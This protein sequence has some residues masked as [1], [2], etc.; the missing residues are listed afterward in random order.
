[1][2]STFLQ[3][4]PQ[5]TT[6]LCMHACYSMGE[7]LTRKNFVLVVRNSERRVD[8]ALTSLIQLWSGKTGTNSELGRDVKAGTL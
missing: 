1:M 5:Q 8:V 6:A 3:T 7:L 4:L 2:Y